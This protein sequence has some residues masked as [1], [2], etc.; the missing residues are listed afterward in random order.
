MVNTNSLFS[1][2]FLTETFTKL[3]I[4]TNPNRNKSLQL[5]Q[6]G[7]KQDFAIS[8][9]ESERFTELLMELSQEFV[10][11]NIPLVDEDDVQDMAFLLMESVKLGNF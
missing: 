2:N 1:M 6:E 8:V 4:M 11:Q 5:L 10:E 7:F 3:R 9:I